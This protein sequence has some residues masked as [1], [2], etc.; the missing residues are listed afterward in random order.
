KAKQRLQ[1]CIK[2]KMRNE[3]PNTFVGWILEC[4]QNEVANPPSWPKADQI[5]RRGDAD[6]YAALHQAHRDPL[7]D[8]MSQPGMHRPSK[9]LMLAGLDAKP[10]QW[11]STLLS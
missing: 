8:S 11:R 4:L 9:M 7:P 5:G 10:S 1:C 6:E 2:Q 3:N